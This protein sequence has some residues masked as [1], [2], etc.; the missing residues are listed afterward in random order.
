MKKGGWFLDD[1][2]ELLDQTFGRRGC[3]RARGGHVGSNNG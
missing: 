3:G 2:F 1:G